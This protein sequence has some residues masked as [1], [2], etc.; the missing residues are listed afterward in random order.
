MYLLMALLVAEL[1]HQDG[2]TPLHRAAAANDVPL[3]EALL[4]AGAV[5]VANNVTSWNLCLCSFCV[6]N[7]KFAKDLASP[8]VVEVIRRHEATCRKFSNFMGQ[9]IN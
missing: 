7:G 9:T 4:K 6:Q 3:V 2:S 1:P 8:T 5:D